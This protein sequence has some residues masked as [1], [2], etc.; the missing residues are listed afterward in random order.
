VGGSTCGSSDWYEAVP[1]TAIELNCFNDWNNK[2]YFKYKL[3]I[4]ADDCISGGTVTP[5]VDDVVVNF[6]P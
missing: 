4:C 2:R 3:R 1:N 5:Q 6:S